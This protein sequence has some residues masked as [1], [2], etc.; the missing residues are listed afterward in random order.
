MKLNPTRSLRIPHRKK[1]PRQKVIVIHNPGE[2]AQNQ[3]LTLEFPDLGSNDVIFP[4]M[5]NLSFN[6]EL[7][8]KADSN[9]ALVSNIGR[10]IVQSSSMEM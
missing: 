10:P 9:R 7:C 4:G 3:S 8:S 5:A 6:T 1:G 2:I